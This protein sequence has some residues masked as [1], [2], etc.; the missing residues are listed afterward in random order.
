MIDFKNVLWSIAGI[1]ITFSLSCD[2]NNGQETGEKLR[3]LKNLVK[4]KKT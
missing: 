2:T 4:T 1:T 3:G